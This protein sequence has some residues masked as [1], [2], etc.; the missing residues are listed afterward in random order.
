MQKI[1]W[2]N[3]PLCINIILK[4]FNIGENVVSNPEV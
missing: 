1:I 2:Q 3:K 4:F